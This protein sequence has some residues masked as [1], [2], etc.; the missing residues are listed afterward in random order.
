MLHVKYDLTASLSTEGATCLLSEG[1]TC[2]KLEGATCL[3]GEL[4]RILIF[5]IFIKL[6]LDVYSK[7]FDLIFV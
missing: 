3:G 1:A 7:Y 2:L 6:Q 4:T 5:V